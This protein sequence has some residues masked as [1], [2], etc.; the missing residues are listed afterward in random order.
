MTGKLIPRLSTT[1]A[2]ALG[3]GLFLLLHMPLPILLGPMFGCLAAALLGIRLEG[4]GTLG[5]AMRTFLGVAIGASV[6]WALVGALAGYART[7]VLIP[8]FV[9]VIGAVAYPFLRRVWG[10]D[11]ATAFYSA[12]PGGLQDMLIFGEEAGGNVRTM[13]LIHATRVLLTVTIAPFAIAWFYGVDLTRPPGLPASDLPVHEI[14]IMVI[15]G[16]AGWKIAEWI[17]MFGASILGPLILTAILSL[18]GI[19][20][21][22]PPVEMIWA[23]Q[24]FIGVAVGSK[25]TGI[26]ARELRR[27]VG[28]GVAMSVL[29]AV[30][31]FAFIEGAHA[32]SPAGGLDVWLAFLP[33]GQAE[34]VMVAIVAGADVAFVVTHHLVRI[35]TVI[36]FAP[37][38]ARWLG[39]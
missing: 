39:R 2:A 11:H 4:Y 35:F 19:I 20:E 17:G 3:A 22:R 38:A 16:L 6:T 18:S 34:M 31:S 32:L 13:S 25:Y 30:I 5:V 10:F 9:L 28:A 21:H 7:L 24:F 1:V 33:G 23:A 37:I 15:A 26:T 14:V 27:D 36:L 12:M 8:V 29:L